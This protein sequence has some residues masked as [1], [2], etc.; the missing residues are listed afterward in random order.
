V[1]GVKARFV[2]I[3]IGEGPYRRKRLSAANPLVRWATHII[4][5]RAPP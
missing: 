3:E 4:P 1:F 2:P 5:W